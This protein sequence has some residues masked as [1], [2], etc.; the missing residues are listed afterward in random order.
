M[1]K[2]REREWEMVLELV[3]ELLLVNE[4]VEVAVVEAVR[5]LC[6]LQSSRC[7]HEE[8]GMGTSRG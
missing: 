5:S 8:E 7:T 1:G 3:L 2:E 4:E 6:S